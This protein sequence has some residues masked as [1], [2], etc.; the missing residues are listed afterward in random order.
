RRA[1]TPGPERPHGRGGRGLPVTLGPGRP[2]AHDN[3]VSKTAQHCEHKPV[4]WAR[5]S[6]GP[7]V[8]RDRAIDARNHV[9][10]DQASFRV[11]VHLPERRDAGV[12]ASGPGR[13][14]TGLAERISRAQPI[15]SPDGED[16]AH[17]LL[18]PGSPVGGPD[19]A[20]RLPALALRASVTRGPGGR[21]QSREVPV[22]QACDP[23]A[24][25]PA[26][27]HV[28]FE[29][30]GT[31]SLPVVPGPVV[32]RK[33]AEAAARRSSARPLRH[34]SAKLSSWTEA[35]TLLAAACT[36]VACSR[37]VPSGSGLGR[38]RD[39]ARALVTQ[40]SSV[41]VP[42]NYLVGCGHVPKPI[43]E[44]KDLAPLMG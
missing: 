22:T 27:R 35:A 37:T 1:G 28:A 32:S 16:L 5:Q 18:R 44:L 7:A 23:C 12:A 19:Q 20:A 2:G 14:R 31:I 36:A 39:Q 42:D 30:P 40:T 33:A 9:G 29:P 38:D 4:C 21:N 43:R 41:A 26:A 34:A 25:R 6:A 13:D 3:D 8:N 15:A 17:A 11:G 24:P 10:P